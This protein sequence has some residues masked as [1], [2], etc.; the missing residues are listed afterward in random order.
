MTVM[1][2]ALHHD[3]AGALEISDEPLCDDVGHECV[4]VMLALPALELHHDMSAGRRK[5]VGQPQSIVF[6]GYATRSARL[7]RRRPD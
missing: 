6:G 2:R 7:Q 3:V 5:R 1:R 4:R